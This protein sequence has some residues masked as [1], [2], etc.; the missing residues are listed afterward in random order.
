MEK[1]R[2]EVRGMKTRDRRGD[3]LKEDNRDGGSI[4]MELLR[5]RKWMMEISRC[6]CH[7]GCCEEKK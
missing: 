2:D 4:K 5:H 3:R 1:Y 7:V 6:P